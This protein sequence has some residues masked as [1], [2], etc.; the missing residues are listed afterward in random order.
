MNNQNQEEAQQI[1]ILNLAPQNTHKIS[2]FQNESSSNTSSC[3]QNTIQNNI[4]VNFVNSSINNQ[5]KS[6]NLI[7]LN[8]TTNPSGYRVINTVQPNS[9]NN[10]QKVITCN[11]TNPKLPTRFRL[12]N[13]GI[14]SY[15]SHLTTSVIKLNT[16]A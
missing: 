13:N 7:A 11:T 4:P 6:N 10:T 3:V 2:E 15:N 5:T 14:N 16:L 8:Q 12:V 1:I 9:N